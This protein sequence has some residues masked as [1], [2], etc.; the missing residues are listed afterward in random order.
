MNQVKPPAASQFSAFISYSHDD[1]GWARWLHRELET[2]VVPSAFRDRE[3]VRRATGRL[4]PVF[5]DREE[6]PSAA[7]LSDAILAA[8]EKSAFLVVICSRRAAASAYVSFEIEQF[9]ALGRD[10]QILAII[11]DGEPN[12]ATVDQECFPPALRASLG[13]VEPLAADA[14]PSGDGKRLA[15]LKIVA[16]LLGANLGQLRERDAIRRRQ[17]TVVRCAIGVLAIAALSTLFVVAS[18]AGFDA[19]GG[20]A[21]RVFADRHDISLMRQVPRS[22]RVQQQ[23]VEVRDQFTTLASRSL[24]NEGRFPWDTGGDETHADTWT[25]SQTL[26]ALCAAP[27]ASKA[28]G[29]HLFPTFE[30]MFDSDVLRDAEGVPSG[31]EQRRGSPARGTIALWMTSALALAVDRED[32]F[33]QPERDVLKRHLATATRVADQH[34]SNQRGGWNMFAGSTSE[35]PDCYTSTLALQSLLLLE[36]SGIP[37]KGSGEQRRTLIDDTATWLIDA[38]NHDAQPP[39]WGKYPRDTSQVYDGLTLQVFATLLDA[40]NQGRV[41]LPDSLIEDAVSH[42]EKCAF[43]DHT[44]PLTTAE[45]DAT[46]TYADGIRDENEAVCFF[47][48][49]WAIKAC[50]ELLQRHERKPLRADKHT[51]VRRSLAHLVTLSASKESLQESRLYAV[52]ELLFNLTSIQ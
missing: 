2:F 52:S 49:P 25:T 16:A 24:L 27:E 9:R 31:W 47:W 40:E 34:A 26:A 36:S 18:D 41:T 46:V 33:S 19:P 28:K 51:R 12:A 15:V 30:R 44:F 8:L 45:F 21:V 50:G 43:R 1:A 7:S 20:E 35:N 4:R 5:R 22:A 10:N 42:A 23:A 13:T 48:H 17:A 29:I 14:R 32:L 6:L 3:T 37:W 38:Y 39:G 11:I